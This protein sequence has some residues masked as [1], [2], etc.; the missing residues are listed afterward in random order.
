[1]ALQSALHCLLWL[2][3]QGQA[4]SEQTQLCPVQVQPGSQVPCWLV[5]VRPVP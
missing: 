1:M 2:A 4:P 5:Q 3:G